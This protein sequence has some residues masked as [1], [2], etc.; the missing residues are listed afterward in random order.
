MSPPSLSPDVT[1]RL[2]A[3]LI[4]VRSNRASGVAGAG[5]GTTDGESGDRQRKQKVGAVEDA[6]VTE[7]QKNDQGDG[8]TNTV[9]KKTD[10]VQVV[11][12]VE[13]NVLCECRRGGAMDVK[14]GVET[15]EKG[16]GVDE[17]LEGL[18][19]HQN[20]ERPTPFSIVS[21]PRFTSIAPPLR[22]SHK[23]FDSTFRT[24][25]TKSVFFATVFVFPSP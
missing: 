17:N 9:A 7:G 14:R 1:A 13:S 10:L 11:L 21:T 22:H 19:G 24:T 23:T 25:C 18:E 15:M 3:E 6:V 5:G 4:N 12:K 16:V 8:K 2:M 20:E